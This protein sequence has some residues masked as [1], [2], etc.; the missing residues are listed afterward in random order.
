MTCDEWFDFRMQYE[1]WL[2]QAVRIHLARASSSLRKAFKH[3]DLY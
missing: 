1:V 2:M 3:V